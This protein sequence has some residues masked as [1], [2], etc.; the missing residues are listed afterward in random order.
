MVSTQSSF[1][2]L[3]LPIPLSAEATFDNFYISNENQLTI[4][5]LRECTKNR[6]LFFYL[7]GSGCGVSHVLQAIQHEQSDRTIVYLPLKELVQYPAEDVLAGLDTAEMVILDDLQ[8]VVGKEDWE[9]VLFHLYNRLRD[10]NKRLII[11]AQLSPRELPVGLPDLQSRLQW[12]MSYRLSTLSDD[13]K[14][15]AIK[16]RAKNLGLR[17]G[18]E[19]IQY[20]FNH[21][22][23]DFRQLMHF[24]SL[25]DEASM[26]EQRHLT[27]PFVKQVLSS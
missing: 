13:D 3:P 8:S 19:V 7:W 6:E 15:Q 2:Q 16:L 27:I 12:G 14:Q 10:A 4:T 21:Y 5:A 11:G 9:H 26:A 24:L 20:I 22:S 1:K 25:I 23:R 18:D 17:I